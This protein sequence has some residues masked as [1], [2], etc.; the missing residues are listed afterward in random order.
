MNILLKHVYKD[1]V[2]SAAFVL[3]LVSCFFVLPS[4]D[5]IAYLDLHVLSLLLSL[6]LV[7]AGLQKA[8]LFDVVTRKLL[9][10]VHSVRILAIVLICLCFF[11]SMLITNDVALITFVPLAILILEQTGQQKYMI[12]VIVLQTIAANLGSMFTP[13]GNPQ[14]LYLYALSGLSL[15][16]FMGIMG[17]PTAI[18][19]LLLNQFALRFPAEEIEPQKQDVKMQGIL[20]WCILFVVCL[21]CVLHIIHYSVMLAVVLVYVII[22][23][24]TLLKKADYGLLLTFMFFFVFIGNIKNIP[25]INVFLN[26]LITG[27]EMTMGI[28]LSQVIS[29][30]PAAMLLSGFS[31]DFSALLLGVYLGGLGIIIASMASLISYKFYE[32]VDGAKMGKYMLTFTVYNVIFLAILWICTALFYVV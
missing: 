21:L 11:C 27:R 32:A 17:I 22:K 19:F 30:V 13:L 12:P 9:D 26:Q 14:N 6:M 16:E 15:G 3:A 28:L 31:Q 25:E 1:P 24:R 18:S 2:L 4:G 8:G 29:N 5:Y 23:D 20:G 10:M 7:V